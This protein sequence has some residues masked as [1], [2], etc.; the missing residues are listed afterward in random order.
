MEAMRDTSLSA[1]LDLA[2]KGE[3]AARQAE[4]LGFLLDH[5]QHD[6]SRREISTL[7]GIELCSVTGRVKELLEMQLIAEGEQRKCRITGRT[8]YPVRIQ[9]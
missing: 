9:S 7:T 2:G 3:I 6:Y 4:V 5:R 8:V 1:Y